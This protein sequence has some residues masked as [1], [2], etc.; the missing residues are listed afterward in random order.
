MEPVTPGGGPGPAGI[1]GM[2]PV[3]GPSGPAMEP[4]PPGGGEGPAAS[5]PTVRVGSV[6]DAVRRA[7]ELLV[8]HGAALDPDGQFGQLTLSAVIA[9][10][11]A[12]G[13]APDGIVG[14]QTWRA[15]ESP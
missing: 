10:Q 1:P 9:F 7:Q 11:R 8:R 13:L 3:A 6:G 5:H 12:S 14:P 15:L 4:V 2:E